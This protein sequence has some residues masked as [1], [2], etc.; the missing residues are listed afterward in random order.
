MKKQL[1]TAG[2]ACAATLAIFAASDRIDIFDT[3][4][5]FVSVM[6][7]DIEEITVGKA[8]GADGYATVNVATAAGTKSRAISTLGDVRYTPV[9]YEKANEI[10][11]KHAPNAKVVLYDWRNNT[12]YYGEA[13]IDPTKP[14]DWRGCYP[15]CNPHFVIDTDKGFASEFA[16]KGLYSGKVYTDN[17]NFIFW[18]L[19]EMNLLGLDSYSFD[20]PFEPVEISATSVELETYKGAPFLGT[21]TGFLVTPG[22]ARIV[23]KM[24][25]TLTAEFRANGTYVMKST[26]D[27]E[28]EFLDCYDYDD[29][30]NT[31]AYVPYSGR[32]VNPIDLE[33]KTGVEGRFMEGDVM[34]A[35]FHDLL[36][37]KPDNCVRYFAAKGE[38]EFTVASANEYNN[39][40]LV[41]AV[42]VGGGQARYF[43]VTNYG[44]ARTEVTM[45]FSYGSNIGADCTAFAVADGEK[46]FKYDYKGPGYDPVFTFRGTEYGTYTGSGDALS[47][48]GYGACT[49]G[50][51]AGKYTV[52]GGLAT[53]TVG[54]DTRLF[55]LD[56]DAKTYTEMAADEWN[57][58]SQYT[59]EAAVG[60]FG[61]EEE[62]AASYMRI[63]FDKN[64]AGADEP[65]TA[66]VRFNVVRHDGFGGG[67]SEMVASSGRYIYN[68]ATKTIVITNVYMGTSATTSGRRNIV[69]KVSDDLLSMWLDD[70]AEDR[71]YGTGRN[72]SYLLTGEVNTL[73]A[74]APAPAVELAPKYTGAPNMIAFGKPAATETT[75]TFD[76]ETATAHLT[77]KGMGTPI[78]DC[79]AAYTLDGNV[80]T[81]SGIPTYPDSNPFGSPVATDLVLT[82]GEDGNLTS[83]QS[84]IGM[85]M[86]SC[87]EIDF[88]SA[89]LVPA[90]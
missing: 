74:P 84:L 57:G 49:I 46:L 12:D 61:S 32:P 80:V 30:T 50:G 16:V 62:S 52:N 58:Q 85:A 76:S 81:L 82:I 43:Y 44:A 45:E 31:F 27:Y 3:T 68:A 18:S 41:Q 23:H 87:Y 60:A 26:D 51:T 53:V 39:H 66:S 63:D 90:E 77:V 9:D 14:A 2:A 38:F 20:M 36:S 4:G 21:Y 13:Q 54:E 40:L 56:R 33:I 88:S 1:M 59:N 22:Q 6:V 24:P 48:D 86:Y 70:S 69:L 42:P 75:L 37:D 65:G 83:E 8:D 47:L 35:N 10:T 29:Q 71:V 5:S 25:A 17:P 72:G 55:V 7:N 34:F 79:D 11:M 19:A 28:F 89:P 64:F 73:A 78:F 67:V 15:D